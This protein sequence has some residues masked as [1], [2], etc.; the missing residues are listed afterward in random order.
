M[1]SWAKL[2]SRAAFRKGFGMYCGHR[3]PVTPGMWSGGVVGLKSILGVRRRSQALCIMHELE[4]LGYIKFSHD[5]KTKKISYEINDWVMSCAGS[6]CNDGTVY[7]TEGYGFL[8]MP[9]S[10]TER[11]SDNKRIFD[12]SDAWLDL[13]CHTVSKDYGNAFSF[14]APVVQYGK[15]GCALTLEQLGRR[16]GWEK[17][18]VWRFFQKNSNTFGLQ[19]LPGSFGCLIFNLRYDSHKGDRMPSEGKI[20]YLLDSI[21]KASRKGIEATSDSERINKMIAWNSRSVMKQLQQ[22]EAC[23]RVAVSDTNTRAYFSHGRNCKYSR[24][25]IYDCQGTYIGGMRKRIKVKKGRVCPFFRNGIKIF[26]SFPVEDLKNRQLQSVISITRQNANAIVFFQPRRKGVTMRKRES[27]EEEEMNLSDQSK[28]FV[29]FL[30]NRGMLS[31]PQIPDTSIR[32]R[33]QAIAK[34]AYHNTLLLLKHYRD[35]MW[36]MNSIPKEL[37]EELNIPLSDL[38][39][40][41]DRLDTEMS[42]ENIEMENRLRTIQKSRLLIDRLNQAV[43]VLKDKPTDGDI[44]YEVIYRTYIGPKPEKITYLIMDMN[45]TRRRYYKYRNMAIELISIKLWS[46][47]DS[48]IELWLD[49]LEILDK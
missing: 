38:D 11:L 6:E 21:R 20:L 33:R 36:A 44:L 16:W 28:A 31:D 10:I 12:E 13:W 29:E 49:L 30:T 1:K 2:A 42:L 8:G 24:N 14:L 3:N 39:G 35:I 15:Y 46:T 41:L 48:K 40:L 26:F 32:E 25:S 7:A 5:L 22:E 23:D 27:Y 9:R 47:P 19:K 17:T 18:K 4:S 43:N 34:K 45:L 37:R